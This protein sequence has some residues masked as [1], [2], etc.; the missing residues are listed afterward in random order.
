[1]KAAV[2]EAVGNPLV[3]R[4]V[5][6]P[7]RPLGGA[8]V[9]VEANGICRSD[10]HFWQGDWAWL[11]L[12]PLLPHV[13][14]HESSGVVEEVGPE[15]RNFKRG[16]RVIV[17]FSQGEGTCEF[18][19]SGHS[20]ICATPLLPGFVYWGGY[21]RFVAV[22]F[23]DLNLIALPESID[24]VAAASLGCRFMTSFRGVVDRAEV[25]P[26][27]WVAVYGCGGV[28]LSAIHIASAMGANAIGVDLDDAKLELAK[29]MG[30]SHVVNAKKTDPIGAI[31]D[32][33]H[34][35]AHV[36]VDALGTATTCRN[37]VMSL[38][39]RGR[40]LQIGMTTQAEQGEVTLPVDRIVALEL[41]ILGSLG[42]PGTRYSQMLQMVEAHRLA[43]G[44]MVTATVPLEKASET[45]EQMTNFQN[46]GVTI[47]NQY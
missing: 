36:A 17:P 28:G 14:G 21:G 26:G 9:R 20:N 47:I 16:D 4:E 1:M 8:V 2:M 41:Q 46:L 35:G 32:L 6:D 7:Q 27:E 13:L 10:W 3:V 31:F 15:I 19:R 43:P 11:G 5:P 40:H 39:K 42:M 30:A 38:R 24:F 45:L 25:K 18:C 23:A 12:V 37:A 44:A 34:G 29:K 22:P 33:T